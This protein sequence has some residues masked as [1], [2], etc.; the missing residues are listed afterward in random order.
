MLNEIARLVVSLVM[1]GL[2]VTALCAAWLIPSWIIYEI[3][4]KWRRDDA[5]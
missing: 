4:K 2:L 3:W 5:A 1:A